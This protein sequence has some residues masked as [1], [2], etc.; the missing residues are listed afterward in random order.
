MELLK[1]LEEPKN[2][3]KVISSDS[4]CDDV[5]PNKRLKGYFCSDTV[6]NLSARVL[7]ESEIKVRFC[8]I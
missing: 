6:F 1:I 2:S 5:I 7:S 8:A 4:S 3:N